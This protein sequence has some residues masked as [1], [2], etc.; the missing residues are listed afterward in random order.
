M[1][2]FVANWPFLAHAFLTNY[3]QKTCADNYEDAAAKVWED[4]DVNFARENGI[5]K[6]LE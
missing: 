5:L 4:F 1:K 2:I 3:L 6:D